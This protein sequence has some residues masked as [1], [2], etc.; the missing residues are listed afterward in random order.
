MRTVVRCSALS[1]TLSFIAAPTA[2]AQTASLVY[3]LGRDTV[4]IEQYTRT[5][6]S[7]SGEMVQRSGPAVVR[8]QYEVAVGKDGAPTSA[9]LRRMQGDGTPVPNAPSEF[10]IRV[11]ADSAVRD[12]V[13]A[14]SVQHRAFPASKAF[15]NFPVFVYGPLELLAA[16]G[17]ARGA[18]DS[19]PALGA[20]GNL[21]YT[22]LTPAGGDTLRL[23]GAPYAMRLRFDANHRLQLVDGSFTTNKALATRGPGGI[24]IAAVARGMKPTGVLSL[25]DLAR[26]SFGPGGMVL[27]DYGRPHVRERSVWGGTLVPFDSVW[28]AGANDATHLF[29]TR[30]LTIGSL[31]VPPG[32]YTLW[33]QHTHDGT[34][35][36]IN[37]QVGQW[38][39]QYDGAF[40]LGRVPM[41]MSATPSFVEEFSITL[42]AL[43]GNRG[44]LEMAWG[45]SMGSVPFTV[46]SARP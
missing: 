12:I 8:I 28:R 14:D 45:P 31:T 41:S 38:G 25:R 9:T 29:T 27:I 30:A 15:I 44:T 10:R 11:F 13:F 6:S 17:G 5:A 23:L 22:G 26:A 2:G 39:T 16:I 21:G 34:F 33:V 42:R 40:D 43:A 19:I 32:M 20:T 36:I 3:R 18:V 35:L 1:W 4:A 24:D 46:S 7:I 37:K